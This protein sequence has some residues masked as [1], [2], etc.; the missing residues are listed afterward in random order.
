MHTIPCSHAEWMYVAHATNA[1][2]KTRKCY[3]SARRQVSNMVLCTFLFVQH[4]V[5]IAS[6]WR[7]QHA[8][9]MPVALCTACLHVHYSS[10][11]LC[12]MM[13]RGLCAP[14]FQP[15]RG[16]CAFAVHVIIW[17]V[18]NLSAVCVCRIGSMWA[19]CAGHTWGN[20][21]YVCH[22]PAIWLHAAHVLQYGACGG[23]WMKEKNFDT[24]AFYFLLMVVRCG[25]V[26]RC[27]LKVRSLNPN[28]GNLGIIFRFEY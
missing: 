16:M 15:A 20:L 25:R 6:Q 4:A 23:W 14:L 27:I 17:H 26:S 28:R 3:I 7:A 24:V 19:A 11:Q 10:M 22:M 1:C 21:Q 18:C 13:W 8:S 9:I 2:K 12:N 5:C